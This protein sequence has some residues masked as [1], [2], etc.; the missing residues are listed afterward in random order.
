VILFIVN[1]LINTLTPRKFQS[2]FFALIADIK[3]FSHGY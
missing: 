3:D 1:S 2:I